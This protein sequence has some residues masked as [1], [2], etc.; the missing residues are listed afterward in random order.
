MKER[1]TLASKELSAL[2]ER[3]RE[4]DIS[5]EDT[6]LEYIQAFE[7]VDV[8]LKQ[9]LRAPFEDQQDLANEIIAAFII[10]LRRGMYRANK[11]TI[12]SYL[13]GISR[14][15]IRDYLRHKQRFEKEVFF[16]NNFEDSSEKEQEFSELRD[17]FRRGITELDSKYQQVIIMRYY[18]NLSPGEISSELNINRNQVYN[19]LHYAL[20]LLGD[21]YSRQAIAI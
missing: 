14:N 16:E 8:I 19:R 17:R 11:G 12:T 1:S 13:W 6:L 5:A 9:R 3:I 21:I 7:R 20:R 15:K 18:E 2:L 4:G 10:Y